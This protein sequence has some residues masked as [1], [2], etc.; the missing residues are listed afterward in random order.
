MKSVT[1][2]VY[3]A[4]F[5]MVLSVFPSATHV[6]EDCLK[7]SISVCN[8]IFAYKW[9]DLA[10]LLDDLRDVVSESP[11]SAIYVKSGTNQD[12][13]HIHSKKRLE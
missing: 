2:K 1:Y 3:G 10:N 7:L 5:F 4:T 8:Q 6:V 9:A 12:I 13:N 11:L